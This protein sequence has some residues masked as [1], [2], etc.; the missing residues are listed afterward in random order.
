M[1]ILNTLPLDVLLYNIMSNP[2]LAPTD[3]L[4]LCSQPG[5]VNICKYKKVGRYLMQR[6]YPDEVGTNPWRQFKILA[7]RETVSYFTVITNQ[8]IENTTG[9]CV[10][11]PCNGP[12]LPISKLYPSYPKTKPNEMVFQVDN[13][14]GPIVG[15]RWISGYLPQEDNIYDH[16]DEYEIYTSQEEAIRA[17]WGVF[18]H[19]INVIDN[20]RSDD[21]VIT[22]PL[23]FKYYDRITFEE[24]RNT[25]LYKGY[26]VY[27]YY[28][29]IQDFDNFTEQII[30]SIH[31][32][33][34]MS[35][36][37][38]S[39]DTITTDTISE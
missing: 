4:S 35:I 33:E 10:D 1:N 23:G 21:G 26:L 22:G 20:G 2:D 29:V 16:F 12:N 25:M 34:F 36:D 5:M 6:F 27:Y 24:F 39:T 11:R 19:R 14:G 3:I 17:L 38:M 30:Y 7:N 9:I 31:N 15:N 8:D 28:V 13:Y 37:T 32:V 18:Q